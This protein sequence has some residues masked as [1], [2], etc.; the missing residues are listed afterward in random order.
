MRRGVELCFELQVTGPNNILRALKKMELVPPHLDP[1]QRAK[2]V[3]QIRNYPSEQQK[4]LRDKGLQNSLKGIAHKI[5]TK[6]YWHMKATLGQAFNPCT[7]Y[8]IP[9][10]DVDTLTQESILVVMTNDDCLRNL[11]RSITH[12]H[13]GFLGIDGKHRTNFSQ[14]PLMNMVTKDCDNNYFV[15]ALV[16]MG[17]EKAFNTARAVRLVLQWLTVRFPEETRTMNRQI[18]VNARG[19]LE[20]D[21]E[22]KFDPVLQDVDDDMYEAAQLSPRAGNDFRT[23]CNEKR[24]RWERMMLRDIKLGT[25]WHGYTPAANGLSNEDALR[26]LQPPVRVAWGGS[27]NANEYAQAL[28]FGAHA[29]ANNCSMHLIQRSMADSGGT[30]NKLLGGNKAAHTNSAI[31]VVK[32]LRDTPGLHKPNYLAATEECRPTAVFEAGFALLLHEL[33]SSPL[34]NLVRAGEILN[35]QY[36]STPRKRRWGACHVP[37]HMPDHNNGC[38]VLNARINEELVG[39]HLGDPVQLIDSTL[40]WLSHL[41]WMRAADVPAAA[42]PANVPRAFSTSHTCLEKDVPCWRKVHLGMQLPDDP[43]GASYRLTAAHVMYAQ[44]SSDHWRVCFGRNTDERY[45]VPS[46]SLIRYAMTNIGTN[47]PCNEDLRTIIEGTRA[48][49]HT[50]LQRP[51]EYIADENPDVHQYLR[52]MVRS[53]YVLERLPAAEQKSLFVGFKCTCMPFMRQWYCKHSIALT[54]KKDRPT[55]PVRLRCIQI[56]RGAPGR[57]R[58]KKRARARLRDFMDYGSLDPDAEL[59]ADDGSD[60][61]AVPGGNNAN[62]HRDDAMTDEDP[63]DE[64]DG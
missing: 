58:T 47:D 63:M 18:R 31:L 64:M 38:E 20:A 52:L 2:L 21:Y 7:S 45:I 42:A 62:V 3:T 17:C 19:E 22:S 10:P 54:L 25:L 30:L 8:V 11:L 57:P 33:W 49:M 51:E 55:L 46:S 27:D 12:L 28:A 60:D 13:G 40:K 50:C 26:H 16:L 1:T 59:L 37:L 14:L 48:R 39:K 6:N 36:G 34:A 61:D 53:F 5:M 24:L 43:E 23:W 32:L 9:G 41:A 29:R 35:S 4:S 56:M 44:M 15:V